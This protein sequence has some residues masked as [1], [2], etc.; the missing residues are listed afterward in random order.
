[1][2]SCQVYA[3]RDLILSV[4]MGTTVAGF[5]VATQPMLKNRVEEGAEAVGQSILQAIEAS[6]TG[7]PIPTDGKSILKPL[8]D[9]A[10]YTSWKKFAAEATMCSVLRLPNELEII[11]FAPDGKGNFVHGNTDTIKLHPSTSASVLGEVVS[12][13]L[14]GAYGN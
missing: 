12:S 4:C 14:C 7:L 10:G 5:Q 3:V 11:A 13:V 8:L 6:Q 2:K 1:M 9:L